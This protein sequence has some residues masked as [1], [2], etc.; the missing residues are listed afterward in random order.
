[1][2]QEEI[3]KLTADVKQIHKDAEHITDPLDLFDPAK[4]VRILSIGTPEWEEREKQRKQWLKDNPRPPAP[5]PHYHVTTKDGVEMW[6]QKYATPEQLA[7]RRKVEDVPLHTFK[8][9]ADPA[10]RKWALKEGARTRF[11]KNDDDVIRYCRKVSNGQRSIV[12]FY[13]PASPLDKW[14]GDFGDFSHSESW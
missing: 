1:M 9:A 2:N 6:E 14:L 5:P 3:D 11:F 12:E 7:E 10:L 4:E 8:V 13:K